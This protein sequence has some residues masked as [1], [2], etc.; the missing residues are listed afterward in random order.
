EKEE[1]DSV[2]LKLD[3]FLKNLEN[4]RLFLRNSSL[5]KLIFQIYRDTNF[6]DYLAGTLNGSVRQ[7]NLRALYERAGQY[8]S[9]NFSGL[10]GFIRFLDNIKE[11]KKD[12]N[13]AKSFSETEDVVKILSIHKSKGLEFEVVILADLNKKFNLQDTRSLFVCHKELGIAPYVFFAEER[14]RYPSFIRHAITYKIEREAKEEELRILYVAMT[15][16]KQKLILTG[17]AKG[18]KNRLER[19]VSLGSEQAANDISFVLNATNYL[20]L[21]LYAIFRS[22]NNHLFK[23]NV[24]NNFD[25]FK[26][27]KEKSA[28]E[29]LNKIKD[30]D[31]IESSST[32]AEKSEIDKILDYKYEYNEAVNIPAKLTVTEIKRYNDILERKDSIELEKESF[33]IEQDLVPRFL[34]KKAVFSGAD[35][36]KTIHDFL[37]KIDFTKNLSKEGLLKQALE[38]KEKEILSKEQVEI[39]NYEKIEKFF[40]SDLGSSLLKCKNVYKEIP[41]SLM[42]DAKD[43]YKDLNIENEEIFVQGIID[44]LFEQEDGS[45]GIVDYKTDKVSNLEELLKRYSTQ[46]KM[47]T[48]AAEKILNI[49]LKE[50]YI[51]SFYLNEYIKA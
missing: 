13:I 21:I 45:F 15:R 43:I 8:E 49:T 22:K 6:Y 19:S 5:K 3:L 41:F 26:E 37:Q 28:D 24:Q 51:Y 14:L 7:A 9:N 31:F 48:V 12:L 2:C 36:G 4:W 25:I 30:L 27:D 11:N 35:Y 23:I 40:S 1:K 38:L 47:Y 39:I 44:V 34:Q 29:I 32:I 17:C 10:F 42:V 20:D 33:N 18:L 46:M 50:A 16:A